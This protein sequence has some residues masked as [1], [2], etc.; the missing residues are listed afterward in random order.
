MSSPTSAI[1]AESTDRGARARKIQSTILQGVSRTGQTPLSKAM[2]V[3]EATISRLVSEHL[4][5]FCEVLSIIGLKVV[6]V[7]M[8]C[9]DKKTIDS[10]TY[11]AELGMAA[12]KE[13][14][15]ETLSWDD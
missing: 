11:F 7:E 14:P 1:A 13:S 12:V 2:Q 3:S 9:Y 5:K 15:T 6:P 10:L 4:E 8:Q